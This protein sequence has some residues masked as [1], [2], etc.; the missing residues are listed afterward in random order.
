MHDD[1]SAE[2]ETALRAETDDRSPDLAW[3]LRRGRRMRIARLTVS[4]LMIVSLL[5]AGALGVVALREQGSNRDSVAEISM[6]EG[7]APDLQEP[8]PGEVVEDVSER[9]QAEIF[10]IRAVD[11]GGLMMLDGR[12]Y[13]ID[14]HSKTVE[15][16]L[17]WRVPF[18]AVECNPSTCRGLSGNDPATGNSLT[19]TWV[20]VRMEDASWTVVDV[21]GNVSPQNR[22]AV[23]GYSLPSQH[24]PSHWEM[25]AVGIGGADEGFSVQML[26]VWIGP[27]PT[28]ASGSVCSI[29]P[30][31]ATGDPVG[32]P[33]VFF[34]E[35]PRREFD[36]AGSVHGRSAAAP[37]SAT[38]ASVECRQ[39]IGRGWDIA[40]GPE[41]VTAGDEVVAIG[42][43]LMWRGDEGFTS[44]ARCRATLVDD[45]GSVVFEGSGRVEPLWRPG[46]LK[47]YPYRSTVVV[48]T[49]GQGL[50]DVSIGEF[51]C[52][53]A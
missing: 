33:A 4:T 39:Y 20:V 38:E 47:N 21:E 53:S 23:V 3:V 44:A 8:R 17:G 24:E 5:A 46:E 51:D 14:N 7:A 29:Q 27:F 15:S 50:Q 48:P 42:A 10:A 12:G 28:T 41:L 43:E 6:G 30:L 2:L 11:A 49:R 22:D 26:P 19:D 25:H 18:S 13:L 45:V 40:S 32:E 9:Y 35:A 36:R 34:Q 31:N 1:L 52:S 16:E 37:R